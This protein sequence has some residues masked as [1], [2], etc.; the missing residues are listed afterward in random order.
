[1]S[2][3]LIFG[4]LAGAASAL[5]VMAAASSSLGLLLGYLAP[6]PLFFAG[7][8][9][10]VM[11]ALVAAITGGAVSAVYGPVAAGMFLLLFGLPA[12]WLVRQAL[13]A[14]PAAEAGPDAET[15]PASGSSIGG[16]AALEWYPVGSLVVWLVA[17]AAGLV[18]MAWLFTSGSGDGETNGGLS[19]ALQP[20]LLQMF[21]AFPA[22][23]ADRGTAANNAAELATALARIMPA[24]MAVSWMLMLTVNGV[25]AQGL[26]AMLKQNRRPMPR[27]GALTLPRFL[28]IAA[29]VL[30]AA[31]WLLASKAGTSNASTV[32]MA[33]AA[34]A[35]FPMFLR[36]L[37]VVHALAAIAPAKGLV[38]AAFY[39]ALV[40]AGAL[41]GILVVILG[42]IEEWA[43]IR[44]RLAASGTS[45]ESE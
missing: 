21:S 6:L 44:R 16:T 38:L 17:W 39:A 9:R 12:F 24:V 33:L 8:T 15:L 26:A 4:G 35:A 1:M 31:A 2:R 13:L 5:L 22:A 18:I 43:G 28:A 32:A 3:D 11:P 37:A 23:D 25:L 30:F 40:V 20:L 42:L 19:G 41:V 45:R 7:L 36:G 34:I 10:G 29:L 14:R 27:Y